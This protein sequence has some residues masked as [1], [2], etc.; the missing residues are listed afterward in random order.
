VPIANSQACRASG[1]MI[2][3]FVDESSFCARRRVDV[4]AQSSVVVKEPT[5]N[6]AAV[7]SATLIDASEL[8]Q[9]NF[10]PLR[11][12]VVSALLAPPTVLGAKVPGVTDRPQVRVDSP[13]QT[14]AMH[15]RRRTGNR[16]VGG[17]VHRGT[18]ARSL[19]LTYHQPSTRPPEPASHTQRATQPRPSQPT[20]NKTLGQ[21]S[22]L[23]RSDRRRGKT[24]PTT[25]L[26]RSECTRG[27]TRHASPRRGELT[28]FDHVNPTD[29][30][31]RSA[32]PKADA[33]RRTAGRV[34]PEQHQPIANL[35]VRK[36]R[37]RVGA[38]GVDDSRPRR[39]RKGDCDGV[40]AAW[41]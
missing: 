23:R 15:R 8:R 13:R 6:W 31:G 5:P 18:P 22:A 34:L 40:C 2:P 41:C 1:A 33:G 24:A 36:W 14:L 4:M 21:F 27:G 11:V 17:P 3:D 38:F 26:R 7:C 19:R 35:P 30:A 29:Q 10:R 25:A 32:Q 16:P 20:R 39:W 12:G 28:P 37:H 9:D